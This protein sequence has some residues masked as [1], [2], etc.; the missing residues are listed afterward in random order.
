VPW[1]WFAFGAAITVM[2]YAAASGWRTTTINILFNFALLRLAVLPAVA[3]LLLPRPIP[4]AMLSLGCALLIAATDEVLEYG[5]EGWLWAFVGLAH[6]AALEKPA[7]RLAWTRA[8]LAALAALAYIR[9]EVHDYAFDL[10]QA[11][12]L[13]MIVATLVLCFTGFR[14]AVLPWQPPAP[15]AAL[16]RVC[17]RRSLE[18]YGATLL[19]MQAHALLLARIAAGRR[20]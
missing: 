11:T 15:L 19:A 2:N 10:V 9:R 8:G 4:L 3:S 16:L 13:V 18:I 5:T 6:R 1:T 17:G 20:G 12:V 14:R 7:A